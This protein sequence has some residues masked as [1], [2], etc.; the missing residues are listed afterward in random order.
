MPPRAHLVLAE[1]AQTPGPPPDSLAT[2][3]RT[4]SARVQRD[5]PLLP[6][7]L[8]VVEHLRA[9][10][11]VLSGLDAGRLVALESSEVIIG[12]GADADLVIHET[13]VSRHHARLVRTPDGSFQ[14][15]DLGS[16]NGTFVGETRVTVAPLAHGHLLQLGPRLRMRF[17]IVDAVDQALHQQLYESSVLDPLTKVFNR[18]YLEA[19]LRA[20]VARTRRASGEL[21]LLMIDVDALKYVNDAFGHLSGDRAL[22]AVAARIHRALRVEDVLVRFGGD[23]FVVLAVGTDRVD[24]RQLAERLRSGVESMH[25]SAR[26]RDVHVTASIGVASLAEL[27]ANDE[28]LAL[29]AAADARM[30]RAKQSGKNR[31]CSADEV[32]RSSSV[33]PESS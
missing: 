14:V 22:C 32:A 6:A 10:V 3:T 2:E 5:T 4:E 27:A 26:G 18:R 21:A 24:A 25:M 12:S 20:E 17:A 30:Y 31:V 29:L 13:G 15:E 8:P 28:P 7:P 23:E 16:V 9:T 33:P 1:L 11:T 19:R